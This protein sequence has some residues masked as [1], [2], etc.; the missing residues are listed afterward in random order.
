MSKDDLESGLDRRAFLKSAA[1]TAVAAAATGTGAALLSTNPRQAPAVVSRPLP[2][3]ALPSRASDLERSA[4]LLARLTAAEAKN[5]RLEAELEATQRR[6][7]SAQTTSGQQQDAA[8]RAWQSQLDDANGRADSMT[9]Q[10]GILGGLVALYEEL[11]RLD[12]DTIVDAGISSIGDIVNDLLE[13]VP[14]LQEGLEIGQEALDNFEEQVP[15]VDSGRRWLADQVDG[16]NALYAAVEQALENA[17]EATGQFI[18]LLEAWFEDILK[19]LP[20]GLGKK[21]SDTMGAMAAL[22]TETPRTL[23]GLDE[24]VVRPLDLWL[25]QEEGESRIKSRL[26]RPI[27]EKA[28][29][30][31]ADTAGRAE[32]LQAVYQT[33]LVEPARVVSEHRRALNEQ[34]I[35]YRQLHQI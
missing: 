34:I 14:G 10:V 31:A 13:S 35:R 11:E 1:I 32:S 19:W 2:P 29:H 3:P 24:N 21:A 27:R 17:L 5:V 28:L 4:D 33:T 26:I 12:V 22:L 30:R 25:E 15:L 23:A 9:T 20:F 16:V 6:L 18:Q 8:I 7:V